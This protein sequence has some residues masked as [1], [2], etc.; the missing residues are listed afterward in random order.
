MEIASNGSHSKISF[1]CSRYFFLFI[2]LPLL[3][4]VC[5]VHE[6]DSANELL[7][8]KLMIKHNA[9]HRGPSSI[10]HSWPWPHSSTLLKPNSYPELNT[11]NRFSVGTR[12]HRSIRTLWWAVTGPPRSWVA[13]PSQSWTSCTSACQRQSSCRSNSRSWKIQ[14]SQKAIYHHFWRHCTSNTA[15][16]LRKM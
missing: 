6:N 10:P 12:Q 5:S 7:V 8:I 3:I 16:T 11:W 14:K 13:S 15:V 1:C 4:T 9:S 2:D